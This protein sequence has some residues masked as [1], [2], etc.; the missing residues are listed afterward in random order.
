MRQYAFREKMASLPE[1]VLNIICGISRNNIVT[2][3]WMS[4]MSANLYIVMEFLS[5][6][7]R[8]KKSQGE[9]PVFKY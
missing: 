7:E 6:L 8:A 9:W 2:L 3:L 4:G 1:T 5:I